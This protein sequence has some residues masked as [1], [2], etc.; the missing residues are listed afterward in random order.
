MGGPDSL[1]PNRIQSEHS[2]CDVLPEN[3]LR[4]GTTYHMMGTTYHI[5]MF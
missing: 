1:K 4:M 5:V 2:G 3:R